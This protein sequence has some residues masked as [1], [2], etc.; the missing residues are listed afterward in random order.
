MYDKEWVMK[1]EEFK[2]NKELDVCALIREL[3][4]LGMSVECESAK[5]ENNH[6]ILVEK[7]YARNSNVSCCAIMLN[8]I[9]SNEYAVSI[10]SGGSAV[11]AF[12]KF[13]WGADSVFINDVKNVILSI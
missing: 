13:S 7:Y 11:G 5:F 9:S 4:R 3:N 12:I 1:K 8:Q 2:I 10:L 6:L